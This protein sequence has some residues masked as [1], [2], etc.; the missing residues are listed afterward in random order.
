MRGR[1]HEIA[2][3]L[4]LDEV[5]GDRERAAREADDRLPAVELLPDEANGLEHERHRLSLGHAEPLDV[6]EAGDRL[7][8]DRADAVDELDDPHADHRQHDVGEHHRRVDTVTALGLE[9]HLGAELGR[10]WQT[11]K[12]P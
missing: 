9:R 6:P 5:P 8:H 1:L 4:A 2:R 10:R 7:S 12:R 3:R 11:S